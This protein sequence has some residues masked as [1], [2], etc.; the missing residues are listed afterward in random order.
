[1]E[2][3]GQHLDELT[4]IDSFLGYVVEDGL[5]AVALILHIADF[6]VQSQ[7]LGYLP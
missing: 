6:H 4:E 3:V 1:M 7:S 5:V 2:C